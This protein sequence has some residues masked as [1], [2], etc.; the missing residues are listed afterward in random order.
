M[1]VGPLARMLMLVATGNEQAK[2]L[3][4]RTLSTLELPLA[5]L[6]STLG[7]TAARTLETKI[8]VDAMQGWYDALVANVKAG[9]T[10]TFD[11]RYWDPS[12]WPAQARGAGFMEAPRGALGHWIVIENGRID[13]YQAV[14]PS[15][16]NAGPRDATGQAGAYEA[17]L[18]GHVLHDP[19]QPIE[20][21]RTIHSFD[22]CIACAVHV[23]NPDGGEA[24]SVKFI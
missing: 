1:E 3:V 24:M 2:E 14:V 9:D 16:W 5:G 18:A 4:D 6:Y 21:L 15:T 13:N 22:P 23:L 17:A 12:T 8:F 10:R 11:D 20:I 19:D 7:R